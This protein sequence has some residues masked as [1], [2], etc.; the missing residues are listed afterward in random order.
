M[1]ERLPPLLKIHEEAPIYE[2]RCPCDVL[3]QIAGEEHNW[4]G[5]VVRPCGRW[6]H[7]EAL[8][9]SSMNAYGRG[10]LELFS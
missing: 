5:E 6:W 10:V 4:S 8:Y 1:V 9:M 3:R 7:S 2:Q